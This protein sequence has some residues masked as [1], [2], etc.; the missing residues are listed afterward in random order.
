MATGCRGAL[1]AKP[2]E[3]NAC[4]LDRGLLCRRMDT[5]GATPGYLNQPNRALVYDEGRMVPTS[6]VGEAGDTPSP[7][8]K[9]SD[10]VAI[11]NPLQNLPIV[12]TIYRKLTGDEP[13]PA[14]RVLGGLLWGGPLGLFGAALTYVAEQVS[15]KNATDLVKSIFDGPDQTTTAVAEGAAPAAGEPAA[16]AAPAEVSAP[17][18]PAAGAVAPRE[19]VPPGALSAAPS[20]AQPPQQ[21]QGAIAQT[22]ARNAA[23]RDLAFYQAH[24]G[25]RVPAA[26]SAPAPSGPQSAP[27]LSTFHRPVAP[28]LG[29]EPLAAP[30]QAARAQTPT[31]RVDLPAASTMPDT[32]SADFAHRMMQGLERYRALNRAAEAKT[33]VLD[34]AE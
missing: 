10:L 23:T 16:E 12:G 28:V 8:P 20:A 13:H 22:R 7:T 33:P 30:A 1:E 27:Q 29:S 14:A 19:A 31:P 9:F 26:S 32:T 4:V 25:S 2:L 6:I 21:Q 3:S 15:G 11:L 34:R 17:A 24:A 5:V 18:A